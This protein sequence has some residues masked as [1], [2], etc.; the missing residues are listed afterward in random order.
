MGIILVGMGS[1][2][3]T[4][5]KC[6][7]ESK[8]HGHLPLFNHAISVHTMSSAQMNMHLSASDLLL[9][10]LLLLHVSVVELSQSVIS[11]VTLSLLL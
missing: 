10:L 6:L 9:L 5:A 8:V 7:S 11:Q 4:S 2:S 1:S 3:I